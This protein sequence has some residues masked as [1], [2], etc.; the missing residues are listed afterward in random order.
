MGNQNAPTAFDA[1][2]FDEA[3]FDIS[4][5][6][7]ADRLILLHVITRQAHKVDVIS[8]QPHQAKTVT[9]SPHDVKVITSGG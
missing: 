3:Q 7:V 9:S 4:L 5:I 6:T 8:S 1:F 2:R